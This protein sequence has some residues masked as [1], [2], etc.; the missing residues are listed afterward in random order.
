MIVSLVERRSGGV[1][2]EVGV[3]PVNGGID[4]RFQLSELMLTGLS[5]AQSG[6]PRTEES[7]PHKVKFELKS[8]EIS[9]AD[10]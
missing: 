5:D 4:G 10:P 9:L 7:G 2:A 3:W 1:G 8:E 6:F